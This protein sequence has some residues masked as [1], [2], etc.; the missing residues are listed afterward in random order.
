MKIKI[1]FHGG[2]GYGFAQDMYD[3]V[4]KP[5]GAKQ[6]TLGMNTLRY[7]LQALI[8]EFDVIWCD[9]EEGVQALMFY[10][11]RYFASKTGILEDFTEVLKQ[12]SF[13]DF[14]TRT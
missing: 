3:Y 13:L 5:L 4:F 1:L 2:R 7:S 6:C 10:L 11:M 8:N 12:K 9:E 14:I